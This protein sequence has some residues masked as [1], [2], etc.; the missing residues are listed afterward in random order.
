M[1]AELFHADTLCEVN[2]RFSQ[3]CETPPKIRNCKNTLLGK[4]EA[5]LLLR[6]DCDFRTKCLGGHK[7]QN[8]EK[9]FYGL[10][11]LNY[12]IAP[13]ATLAKRERELVQFFRPPPVRATNRVVYT[14]DGEE[15]DMDLLF[16]I[17]VDVLLVQHR[18]KERKGNDM[19]WRY[20]ISDVLC[21][22]C[23]VMGRAMKDLFSFL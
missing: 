22:H 15:T 5:F 6:R 17:E 10:R 2:S 14:C 18:P 3:F 4:W 13:W 20:Q 9:C 21:F 7:T 19:E 8:V 11:S 23:N 12:E 16:R 1:G